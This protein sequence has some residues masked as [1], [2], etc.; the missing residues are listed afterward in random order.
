M[1]EERLIPSRRFREFENDGNWEQRK[2]SD[3][4]NITD[5]DRGKNYPSENDFSKQGHTLFLSAMNV[6]KY[7]FCFGNNQY[8]TKEK[9]EAL[10]NGKLKLNDIVLTSRGSLGH[11]A[12]YNNDIKNLIPF[13]RINSGML[14]LNSKE[15]VEPT[16]IAQYLNSPLGKKQIDFISFGS[17]QPQLTKK[18]VSNY[19]ISIPDKDE[20]AKIGTFFKN[21]DNLITLQQNKL[22]KMKDLKSA[23]LSEMFPKEGEKY[24]KRRFADFD[25]PWREYR[26][27]E[28]AKFSKGRGYSKNDLTEEGTPIILYGSLYTNYKTVINEVNT[29]AVDKVNSVYS[30]GSEVVV[31]SSGESSEDIARASAIVSKGVIIGGDLNVIHSNSNIDPIFLALLIS[32]GERKTELIKKAQGK[33]VVHLYNTDLKEINLTYPNREEQT[34]ISSFFTDLDNILT[35]HQNKLNKLKDLKKA[36]LSEMFV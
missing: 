8:I 21:L 18:D 25:E 31:P 24:P 33:S 28:V 34:M 17:A 22:K 3:V 16:Y 7:G 10:G 5:G 11:I 15:E 12:L 2:L 30:L 9:S 36:Y 27:E 19:S 4:T 20:Q 23:Y 13:A 1:K 26:L 29:F 32:N 35:H 6:T 14:I